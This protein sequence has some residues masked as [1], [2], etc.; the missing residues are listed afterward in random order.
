MEIKINLDD[1]SYNCETRT[2]NL[3]QFQQK[4][5]YSIIPVSYWEPIPSLENIDI[6][7]TTTNEILIPINFHYDFSF[8]TEQL[9]SLPNIR[10]PEYIDKN[11]MF[12]PGDIMAYIAMINYYRPNKIIEIGGGYSTC[13]AYFVAAHLNLQ[14]EI[15]C[16]EPEPNKYLVELAK[17]NNVSLCCIKVQDIIAKELEQFES[18]RGN[19]ILFIPKLS[20]SFFVIPT[21]S[22]SF[23]VLRRIPDKRE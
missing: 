13:L 19:D 23:L 9:S 16:I 21:C 20:D 5:G 22:E 10:F 3:R 7:D 8:I 12:P 17:A 14:T 11:P 15:V 2:K 6:D 1:F 18:L 4:Y